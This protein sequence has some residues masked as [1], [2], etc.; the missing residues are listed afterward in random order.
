MKRYFIILILVFI[1]NVDVNSMPVYD[2][3]YNLA[4]ELTDIASDSLNNVIIGGN[5]GTILV[6]NDCG[7]SWVQKYFGTNRNIVDVEHLSGGEFIALNQF[8]VLYK[9]FDIGNTWTELPIISS[10]EMTCMSFYNEI[11]IIGN[12]NGEILISRDGAK[13]WITLKISDS[14]IQKVLCSNKYYLAIDARNILHYTDDL[15]VE[16]KSVQVTNSTALAKDIIIDNKLNL[17][18]LYDNLI[19][20]LDKYFNKINEFNTTI[21]LNS[22]INKKADEYFVYSFDA[23]T[24]NYDK[25]LDRYRLIYTEGSVLFEKDSIVND[26]IHIAYNSII[27][28]ITVINQNIQIAIGK[29]KSIFISNDG[30]NNWKMKSFFSS[31]ISKSNYTNLKTC[32]T[33]N[34]IYIGVPETGIVYHSTDKGATWLYQDEYWKYGGSSFADFYDM[35]FIND[36][37]GLIF[38]RSCYGA[39]WFTNDG[40]KS[41]TYKKLDSVPT[42]RQKMIFA[43]DKCY[44]LCGS[45]SIFDAGKQRVYSTVKITKDN[46]DT[47]NT[48]SADS[49]IMS[50]IGAIDD[51][52]YVISINYFPNKDSSGNYEFVKPAL[53]F[54]NDAG[55]TWTIKKFPEINGISFI[56]FVSKNIAYMEYVKDE[57]YKEFFIARSEDGG[58]S[59][60][61]IKITSKISDTFF[62]H[63]RF[64]EMSSN[65]NGFTYNNRDSLFETNDYGST[66][67]SM[68][69]P[70]TSQITS[71]NKFKGNYYI[72]GVKD[73]LKRT[74]STET[75]LNAEESTEE[76]YAKMIIRKPYPTPFTSQINI[77]IFWATGINKEDF[78][79]SAY[80]I[81]GSLVEKIPNSSLLSTGVCSATINWTPS[82]KLSSGI[83]VIGIMV[84][85]KE[86]YVNILYTK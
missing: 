17:L 7:K 4:S 58:I 51:S 41:F 21:T 49:C 82:S 54:T 11:G 74:A 83:Y 56:K 13:S 68:T 43:K 63:F 50:S 52:S 76:A 81:S 55:N 35:T 29:N 15:N 12:Y 23:G 66:W 79:I 42:D 85:G 45:Y 27:N 8:S 67:E 75:D 72:V 22:L 24:S 25:K 65:G 10:G 32:F 40:A 69:V 59:W 70:V 77:P 86:S 73:I 62:K 28:K 78:T 36:T 71:L 64:F 31:F 48:Y 16:W 19:V 80:D 53:G 84:Q 46:W 33:E 44:G 61:E 39:L 5:E 20:K 37:V 26:T 34:N 60:V 30:G 9:S 18:V 3:F 57:E 6:S 14:K 2:D 1:S 47:Y 38:G